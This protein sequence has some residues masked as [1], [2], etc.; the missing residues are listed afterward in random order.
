M[1]HQL[2]TICFALTLFSQSC[3]NNQPVASKPHSPVAKTTVP[4][5]LQKYRAAVSKIHDLVH[6][7]L[8][9][10]FD[11]D[12]KR[13]Y[14][15]AEIT[16]HPHFYSSSTLILNARGM[17]I[18]DVS[19]V[20]ALGNNKL[21]FD[22]RNDSLIIQLDRLYKKDENYEVNIDYIARPEELDSIGGSA[23]IASDKGLYFINADGKEKF[24]PRQ[25]WTQGET[26]ASSVWFPTIDAPN[27]KMTQQISMTVDS[28]LVTLSNGLMLKSTMNGDG[29]RTDVWVQLLPHAPYLV[30]MAAGNYI[31][32]KDS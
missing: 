26:Q 10:R 16:L 14:G 3:K 15:E 5:D 13:L 8:N 29:T 19:I 24:K 32:V 25:V 23:A 9:V 27:Q 7:S 1:K 31:V 30:M 17:I 28:T 6:T 18:N 11:W 20:R 21:L 2:F 22:Y 12:K 4:A